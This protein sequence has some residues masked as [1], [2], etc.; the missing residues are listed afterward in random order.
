MHDTLCRASCSASVARRSRRHPVS[1]I[2]AVGSPWASPFR[3]TS[4]CFQLPRPSFRPSLQPHRRSEDRPTCPRW[5]DIWPSIDHPPDGDRAAHF[6]NPTWTFAKLRLPSHRL[7]PMHRPFRLI[8]PDPCLAAFSGKQPSLST[9]EQ[10]ACGMSRT[11]NLSTG[12][13]I[14]GGQ[15]W[16]RHYVCPVL[17]AASV[18]CMAEIRRFCRSATGG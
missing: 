15:E 5:P 2:F 7:L 11:T 9:R 3:I 18:R 1:V 13:A 16:K 8:L 10:C 14:S 17:R 6:E 12:K 4:Q